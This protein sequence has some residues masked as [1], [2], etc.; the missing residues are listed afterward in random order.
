[1]TSSTDNADFDH[2]HDD[3]LK[4]RCNQMN[5]SLAL[6][7]IQRAAIRSWEVRKFYMILERAKSF[8]KQFVFLVDADPA[9]SRNKNNKKKNSFE[10]SVQQQQHSKSAA[11]SPNLSN[12]LS[13]G[14]FQNDVMDSLRMNS[15]SF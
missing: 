7:Y 1:M 9:M 2:L 11:T 3:S 6:N 14:D 15:L 8:W 5:A 10:Q 13:D 4:A 12:I